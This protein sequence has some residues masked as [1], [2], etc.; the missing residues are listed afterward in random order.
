MKI[1]LELLSDLCTASGEGLPG[2]FDN[3]VSYDKFGIPFI[4]AKR[5]KGCLKEAALELKDVDDSFDQ[6]TFD[7]L[8]GLPG[9]EAGALKI[10]NGY[11][12]N[13]E[14]MVKELEELSRD[15]THGPY[16]NPA[17]IQSYFT[18]Y[19][20]M[21]SIDPESYT[22][23][24]HTLRTIRLI[25]SGNVFF[26]NVE[27]SVQDSRHVKLLEKCCKVLRNIG[28]NR[29]R[30]WGEVKCSLDFMNQDLNKETNDSKIKL[31]LE[32]N[33]LNEGSLILTYSLKL[34]TPVFVSN[35]VDNSSKSDTYISGSQILGFFAAEY[36]KRMST[37]KKAHQDPVFRKLFLSD[38][39]KFRNAYPVDEENYRC[40]P[41]PLTFVKMKDKED[42]CLDLANDENYQKIMSEEVQTSRLNG[43]FRM[44]NDESFSLVRVEKE[45]QYHHRRPKD[46]TIG[47]A[48]R[49]NGQYFQMESIREGQ[50][51]K[52]YIIGDFESLS[53]LK[54]LVVKNKIVR[55]GRS[56]T[57]QYAEAEF[58]IENIEPL[59]NQEPFDEDFIEKGDKVAIYFTSPM[60]LFD[61]TFGTVKTDPRLF[62]ELLA[63][64][65][66]GF[67]YD[68][69]FVRLTKISG[70]HSKWRMPKPQLDAFD[71]GTVIVLKYE[72][73]E[74][75]KVTDLMLQSY[76]LRQNEGFGEIFVK[77]SGFNF[78]EPRESTIKNIR[79]SKPNFT[80]DIL[81]YIKT[82][83]LR[84]IIKKR[85]VSTLKEFSILDGLNNSKLYKLTYILENAL[86]KND[87]LLKAEELLNKK[88]DGR[89]NTELVNFLKSDKYLE[90][91]A[92]VLWRKIEKIE[93]KN[94]D[95]CLEQLNF[96]LYKLFLLT[97]FQHIKWKNRQVGKEGVL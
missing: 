22:A 47:H 83:Q 57:A 29:T 1:K 7:Q 38:Q 4:P 85:A 53:L 82:E 96:E 8:F 93:T 97:I 19:R 26:F 91:K 78:I 58:S 15:N 50:I 42:E 37:S 6:T 51:F 45:I 68:R 40:I 10:G 77:I 48:Q 70:F 56:K 60:I 94:W 84:Y 20:A 62:A 69:S 24:D 23:K 36:L 18:T 33:S 39:V 30:G 65:F 89:V 27:L 64:K 95:I 2:I 71:A 17:Y 5:I 87:F 16:L 92:D 66:S 11:I 28:L 88:N 13:Y 81:T 72:G 35:R 46:R 44:Y 63:R 21:T 75:I 55:L 73:T 14:E 86:N 59:K 32:K 49:G 9:G 52:G 34:R 80:N 31:R 41:I 61:E 12:A 74:S 79:S 3:D 76:G 67:V 54:D 43:Y 90:Y 25:R